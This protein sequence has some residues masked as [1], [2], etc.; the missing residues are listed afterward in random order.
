MWVGT[1]ATAINACAK[2]GII[3]TDNLCNYLVR[4]LAEESRLGGMNDRCCWHTLNSGR[5]SGRKPQY[6]I[7]LRL[8]KSAYDIVG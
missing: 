7:H 4:I 8:Y 1:T 3:T 2:D 6:G 5:I